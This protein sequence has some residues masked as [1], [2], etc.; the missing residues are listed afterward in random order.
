MRNM[1]YI[2]REVFAATD[3]CFCKLSTEKAERHVA[4]AVMNAG[5]IR[6]DSSCQEF[7][8]GKQFTPLHTFFR[9]FQT[10]E[11]LCKTHTLRKLVKMSPGKS[12]CVQKIV[13]MSV[14][15]M[16]HDISVDT[17]LIIQRP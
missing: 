15:M 16:H 11:E 10:A 12:T 2:D 1:Q 5:R 4:R 6:A 7:T 8:N 14:L 13:V 17:V 9:R 3:C